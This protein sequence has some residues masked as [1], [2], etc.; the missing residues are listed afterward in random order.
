MGIYETL[1][2]FQDAFG[3]TMGEMGTHPWSQGFP[4]TTQLPGGPEMPT[5][6]Y[7]DAEDLKYPKA[8][9]LPALREAIS[10]Y[11]NHYYNA[12]I[13]CENVMVFSGGR[14]GLMAMLMF[15][16]PDINIRIA[17]TEY[18]P[19]YDMLHLLQRK[20][21]LVDSNVD[22]HFFPSVLD[23]VN[24]GD[25]DRNLVML[26]NPCNPTGVTKSGNELKEL[27]E[28]ASYGS[29]GLLIDE[30]YELFHDPPATAL[31]YIEDINRSNLF[32]SGAA[33]KGLQAPGIRIGWIVAAKRYIEI[34][35]NFSSFGMGGVS[36]PSQLYALDLLQQERT[37]LAHKAIPKFYAGQRQRYGNAFAD[38]GLDLFSGNGGFYHWCRLSGELTAVELNNRLFKYGAAVLKGPDTDMAR[39]GDSS[40]LRQF[41]RFSFGPLLPESFESDIEILRIALS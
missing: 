40:A 18:T 13:D 32:V 7:L 8:W 9:G 38:L 17:S 36:R 5:N 29:F 1:Y 39:Q 21:S 12:G 37:D 20:Y 19:Y 15:L 6:V 35:G 10:S 30:A 2:A 28:K 33:T 31:E 24:T 22:N 41:F 3:K 23:Y 4:L 25:F 16:Q 27:V 11:Y 26:S 34:L 14:P